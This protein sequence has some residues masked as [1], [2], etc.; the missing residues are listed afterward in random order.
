M[1]IGPIT[2]NKPNNL[3][4][5]NKTCMSMMQSC[6]FRDMRMRDL[7]CFSFPQ[8]LVI[9]A[10]RQAI[11][12]IKH[13]TSKAFISHMKGGNAPNL[14]L[15]KQS[16]RAF[17]QQDICSSSLTVLLAVHCQPLNGKYVVTVQPEERG[18][19]ASVIWL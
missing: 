5:L 19:I 1:P 14:R 10:E 15:L 7:E 18:K 4:Y 3:S 12:P 2:I 13:G 11:N 16:V 6:K 17:E 9:H 8:P